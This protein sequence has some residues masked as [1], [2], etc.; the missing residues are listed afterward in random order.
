MEDLKTD[1]ALARDGSQITQKSKY[2]TVTASGAL[3]S[4]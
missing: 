2:H 4:S 3:I 1:D